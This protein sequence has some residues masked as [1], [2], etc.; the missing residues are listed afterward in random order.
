MA[1]TIQAQ[2][3]HRALTDDLKVDL[4]TQNIHIDHA[5]LNGVAELIRLTVLAPDKT[6]L[7]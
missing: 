1:P 4:V 6:I 3:S 2:W 5:H 7:A